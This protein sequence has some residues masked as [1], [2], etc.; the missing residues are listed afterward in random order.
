MAKAS[1]YREAVWLSRQ[2]AGLEIWISR[3]QVLLWL[4]AGFVP[5]SP[6]LNSSAV[7]LDSQLVCL[8][9]D[10]ILNLLSLFKSGVHV[11]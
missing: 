10:G 8:L 4:L 11:N 7:L 6:W 5:G 1:L 3:V 9:P 2:G